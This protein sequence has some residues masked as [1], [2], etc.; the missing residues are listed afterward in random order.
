MIA[1]IN[2]QENDR[3]ASLSQWKTQII[4]VVNDLLRLHAAIDKPDKDYQFYDLLFQAVDKAGNLSDRLESDDSII[5]LVT[6]CPPAI[7]FHESCV[8][9]GDH[10]EMIRGGIIELMAVYPSESSR[11]NRLLEEM[12]RH[13][14]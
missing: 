2:T 7:C 4:E 3:I 8:K 11:L 5:E 6:G 12:N 10:S 13:E 9:A 14:Q 1:E